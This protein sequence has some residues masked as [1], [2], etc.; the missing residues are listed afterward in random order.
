MFQNKVSLVGDINESSNFF[1][2][3][4]IYGTIWLIVLSTLVLMG[5]KFVSKVSPIALVCVLLSI[6]A[7]FIGIFRTAVTPVKLE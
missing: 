2:N 7:V 3:V 6:F 5:V 1:W 4:R